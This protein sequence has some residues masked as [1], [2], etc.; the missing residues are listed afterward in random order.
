MRPRRLV[1]PGLLVVSLWAASAWAQ[2]EPTIAYK[3]YP[4]TPE[5]GRSLHSQLHSDT[6]LRHEGQKAAGLAQTPIKYRYQASQTTIGLCRIRNLTVTCHCDITLP[7]LKSDD[8][9]LKSDFNAYLA[10]LKEHELTHCR[11]SAAYAGRFKEAALAL[12][13]RPCDAIKGDVNTL[14]KRLM[15]EQEREQNLFDHNAHM[16]GYQA[17]KGQ[18]LLDRPK[19]SDLPDIGNLGNLPEADP[20]AFWT[21]PVSGDPEP[22]TFYKDKDG[23]WRNY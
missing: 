23:I 21:G 15:A 11:I 6:P 18:I 8:P 7:E 20:D 12:G 4:V 5:V 16:G 10:L 1:F 17:R 14:F 2:V 9:G 19:R 22:G 13:E 3:Y